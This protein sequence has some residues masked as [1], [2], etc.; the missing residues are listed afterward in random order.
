MAYFGG[1]LFGR[2]KMAPIISPKK[3]WEGAIAGGIGGAGIIVLFIFI[4]GMVN[5]QTQL[6]GDN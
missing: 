4:I 6:N 1:V 2:H 3:S 5:D